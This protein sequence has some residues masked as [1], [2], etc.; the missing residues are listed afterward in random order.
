MVEPPRTELV[1]IDVQ[2]LSYVPGHRNDALDRARR[3]WDASPAVASEHVAR[4]WN[5]TGSANFWRMVDVPGDELGQVLGAW[6][7]VSRHDH[8]HLSLG[9]PR[10]A[11][12]TWQLGGSMRTTPLARRFGV[13]IR[14]SSYA[15]YWSMLELSPRHPIKPSR[16]YFRV[17]H[18]SLDLFIATLRAL[19]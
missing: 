3:W 1:E 13:E 2:E 16:L 12:G 8:G 11:G 15:R 5:L 7:R 18:D 9:E 10:G 19:T 6:W 17:G 4:R 14:L